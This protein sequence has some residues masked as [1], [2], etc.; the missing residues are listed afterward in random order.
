M[1]FG[2]FLTIILLA[3]MISAVICFV[4]SKNERIQR[5]AA[6]EMMRSRSD[7]L[8]HIILE[9]SFSIP[10][11]S[12]Q[13]PKSNKPQTSI[14]ARNEKN[15]NSKN[16]NSKTLKNKNNTTVKNTFYPILGSDSDLESVC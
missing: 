7:Q 1:I 15:E 5:H 14:M 16:E 9:K 12:T 4:K 11:G 8:L 10:P 3:L 6:D 13:A 2:G